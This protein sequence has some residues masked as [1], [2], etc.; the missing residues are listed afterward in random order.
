MSFGAAIKAW[1]EKAEL[2]AN[3]S[4][5]NACVFL[6]TEVVDLTKGDKINIAGFSDGDIANNW[7]ISVG[8][9]NL[10]VPNGPDKSG[11]ASLARIATF[12]KEQLFYKK[13]NVIFINNVMNYSYRANTLGWRAGPGTNGWNWSGA[14]P[15]GYGFRETALN[16]LKGR[17]L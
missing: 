3:D 6:S 14:V 7:H 10:V 12:A 2:K 5:T 17:Y 16:N 9:W 11:S 4:V 15:S 13:D 1:A 8:A